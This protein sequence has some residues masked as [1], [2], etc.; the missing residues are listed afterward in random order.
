M[1]AP[2][3][4]ISTFNGRSAWC[5]HKP[6]RVIGHPRPQNLRGKA[7]NA[8]LDWLIY[9]GD[10]ADLFCR[11]A[12]IAHYGH[13]ATRLT[14]QMVSRRAISGPRI[15]W[16]DV[17]E[18][19]KPVSGRRNRGPRETGAEAVAVVSHAVNKSNRSV[20]PGAG[21]RSRKRLGSVYG[22]YQ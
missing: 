14:S 8:M 9:G 22:G 1:K 18:F 19:E 21:E 4:V 17:T 2:Q 10:G 20:S 13:A 7:P 3:R 16:N 5:R 15:A 11:Y 12:P 6:L